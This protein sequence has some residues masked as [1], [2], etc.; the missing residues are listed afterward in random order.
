MR[1]SKILHSRCVSFVTPCCGQ[2]LTTV[3]IVSDG[4]WN[5]TGEGTNP[6]VNLQDRCNKRAVFLIILLRD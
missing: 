4:V 6:S 5:G 2:F 1:G 3:K